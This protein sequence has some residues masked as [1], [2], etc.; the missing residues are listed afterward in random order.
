MANIEFSP[1][2]IKASYEQPHAR[3]ETASN[4]CLIFRY[5]IGRGHHKWPLL[6]LISTGSN[7]RQVI[8]C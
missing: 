1:F 7:E 5:T 8:L 2:Q 4:N 6:A 3:T